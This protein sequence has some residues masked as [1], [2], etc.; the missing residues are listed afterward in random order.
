[1]AVTGGVNWGKVFVEG[2]LG[3][4][5]TG[6]V[7]EVTGFGGKRGAGGSLRV[8]DGSASLAIGKFGGGFVA[9]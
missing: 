3:V 5:R 8:V 1:M 2:G 9:I 6:A 7:K 4:D